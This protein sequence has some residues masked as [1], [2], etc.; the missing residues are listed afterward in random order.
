MDCQY[1]PGQLSEGIQQLINYVKK[2]RSE[3][4]FLLF[5]NTRDE[6]EYISLMLKINS[7]LSVDIHHGSLSK[8]VREETEKKWFKIHQIY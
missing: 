2:I 8:E 5:T 3:V 1:L 6:A 7:K 4:S